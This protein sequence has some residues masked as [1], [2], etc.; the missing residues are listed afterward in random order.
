MPPNNGAQFGDR[1]CRHTASTA[2]TSDSCHVVVVVV[3]ERFRVIE[4]DRGEV[5][6]EQSR[7]AGYVSFVRRSRSRRSHLFL[8]QDTDTYP[9]SKDEYRARL[10][11]FVAQ[12]KIRFATIKS[13][14]RH[15]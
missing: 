5:E 12:E 8:L 11:D 3:D 9:A 14:S 2:A 10:A 4:H 15:I 6:Q 1:H 13:M 7:R